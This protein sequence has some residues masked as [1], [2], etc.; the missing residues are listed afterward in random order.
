M[1]HKDEEQERT[2]DVETLKCLVE[3]RAGEAVMHLCGMKVNAQLESGGRMT[4]SVKVVGVE[5][6][7]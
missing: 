1:S 5:S 6:P 3:A 2:S 4:T 7:V